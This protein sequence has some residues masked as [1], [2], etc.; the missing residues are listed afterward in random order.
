[1]GKMLAAELE[2]VQSNP[3]ARQTKSKARLK[4][5]EEMLQAPPRE[6]LAHSARIYIPP[7]PRLGTQVRRATPSVTY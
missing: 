7:G 4:R 2:W 5:Y 3:K 1:M 6:S